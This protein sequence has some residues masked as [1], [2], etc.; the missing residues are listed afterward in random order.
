MKILIKPELGNEDLKNLLNHEDLVYSYEGG[1]SSCPMKCG[2]YC[3]TKC[4]L[5]P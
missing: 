3:P 2:L 5:A 4:G 1:E